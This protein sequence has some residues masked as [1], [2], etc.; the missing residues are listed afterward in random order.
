MFS[1]FIPWYRGLKSP[2]KK[3]GTNKYTS[4]GVI[5][6]GKKD[7]LTVTELPVGMWT[8]K[9]KD[10]CEDLVHE[11]QLKSMKNYSTPKEV[12]IV[13]NETS[14][15]IKCNLENLKL[16]SSIFTSN[17]VVFDDND[18]LKKYTN[19]DEIVDLFCQVRF[20]FYKKRKS[21]QLAS[22]KTQVNKLA[23]K[24]KFIRCVVDGKIDI[25]NRKETDIAVVLSDMK[26]E[27]EDGSYDY[28]FRLQV[29]TFTNEK[30]IEIEKELTGLNEHIKVL[31]STSEKELWIRDLSEFET[32]YEKFTKSM[33]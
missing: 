3:T 27:Q 2:L 29:R 1:E 7:S 12:K 9:F 10:A 19:V 33:K 30:L 16:S 26:I 25:M 24:L 32:Q 5:E 21:H 14:N 18:R 8:N 23:N 31:T 28:L 6:Q 20:K 15:G 11:K 13:L 4:Y 22:L 17:M